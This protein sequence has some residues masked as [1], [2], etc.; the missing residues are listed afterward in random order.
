MDPTRSQ[1]GPHMKR[2][3]RSWTRHLSP[4]ILSHLYLNRL[5]NKP[6]TAMLKPGWVTYNRRSSGA[7][8]SL[9]HWIFQWFLMQLPMKWAMSLYKCSLWPNVGLFI[10]VNLFIPTVNPQ[11]L[12]GSFINTF[13]YK[14]PSLTCT[15]DVHH[16]PQT[17]TSWCH[18]VSYYNKWIMLIRLKQPSPRPKSGEMV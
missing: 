9:T 16:I 6:C 5:A 10:S 15:S 8:S 14:I 17:Y 18:I 7:W 3:A 12:P 11:L 4:E 1:Q 13:W 2:E